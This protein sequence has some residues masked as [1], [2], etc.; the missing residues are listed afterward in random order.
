MF[1]KRLEAD[2]LLPLSL[3]WNDE[4]IA[5]Q[6]ACPSS[7]TFG[8]VDSGL[9][10]LQFLSGV[11]RSLGSLDSLWTPQV[12]AVWAALRLRD[13]RGH[14]P[15]NS[16]SHALRMFAKVKKALRTRGRSSGILNPRVARELT[17]SMAVAQAIVSLPATE[18][19]RTRSGDS[20]KGRSTC[21]TAST[22]SFLVRLPDWNTKSLGCI[23][24]KL[25][26]ITVGAQKSIVLVDHTS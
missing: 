17:L 5:M 15:K 23:I 25:W 4:L 20:T 8:A 21:P 9:Q 18:T 13:E 2:T 1:G 16:D 24:W 14:N 22:G 11:P 19:L 6:L 3:G 10:N 26:A 7:V 12:E